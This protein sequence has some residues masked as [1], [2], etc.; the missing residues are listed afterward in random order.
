MLMPMTATPNGLLPQGVPPDTD[1][2]GSRHSA[3]TTAM[4]L[5]RTDT[6]IRLRC[7]AA[8]RRCGAIVWGRSVI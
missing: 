7:F 1:P 4:G 5:H 3:N 2:E 6:S 8:Y